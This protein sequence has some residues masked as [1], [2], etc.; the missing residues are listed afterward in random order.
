[1]DIEWV[2]Q[3][4]LSFPHV[5][6]QVQWGDHLVFKIGGKIFAILS[7]EPGGYFLSLKCTQE[8]YAVLTEQPGV[9]PAPYL[10]RAYWIALETGQSLPSTEL[11]RLLRQAYD[12]VFTKLP[13]KVRA[14]MALST[15]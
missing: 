10:A 11:K 5:T 2:R 4:C 15:E 7:L 9:N 6:E 12:L 13:R 8:E 3:H 14:S 1:M